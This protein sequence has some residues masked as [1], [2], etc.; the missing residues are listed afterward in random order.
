MTLRRIA[1]APLYLLADWVN[2]NPMSAIGVVVTLGALAVLLASVAIGNGA[3][4]GG[5]GLDE[6]TAG[7]LFEAALERPAYLAAVAVGLVVVLFY[8]G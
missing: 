2:D 7:L 6:N 5:L 3:E 8:N 1:F 4:A